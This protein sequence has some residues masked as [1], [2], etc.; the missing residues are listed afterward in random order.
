MR[1]RPRKFATHHSATEWWV[2]SYRAGRIA[3]ALDLPSGFLAADRSDHADP[4]AIARTI[5]C[6]AAASAM[7]VSPREIATAITRI[8]LLKIG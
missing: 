3:S 2:A 4:S 7:T 6:S 5:Y 8:S 1:A